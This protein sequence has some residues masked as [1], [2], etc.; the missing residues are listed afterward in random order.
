MNTV[1]RQLVP[2]AIRRR[3]SVHL[4]ALR[5]AALRRRL[6]AMAVG[7]RP[8]LA[9]PWLGEV[10]FEVLYWMPFLRWF[11][12]EYNIPPSR[13]AVISR[14]GT[15]S[16]YQPF[17]GSYHDVFDH[18]S[19][20]EFRQEHDQRI[21][22]GGQQKQTCASAFEHR[23]LD[24]VTATI[25][26]RDAAVLHPSTMY[27]IL[28]P[29][30]WKHLDER[31]VHQHTRYERLHAPAA[32]GIDSLPDSYV[33]V[34]FYFNDCFPETPRNVAFVRQVVGEIA[35]RSPVVSLSTGLGLD[36]HDAVALDGRAIVSLPMELDARTNLQV[37]SA[38]LAGA[39]AFV[40]TYGG[41][42]Y[43]A[44]FYGVPTVAYY[45][46][47]AGFSRRHLT[48]ARS[49]LASVGAAHLFDVRA[50]KDAPMTPS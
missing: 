2:R 5:S 7:T 14:G 48:M 46:D 6:A 30:W 34:K 12:T 3:A 1:L 27:E 42:S 23:L 25:G 37:Q 43:L 10:G 16:W 4:A 29:F 32:E 15:H 28:N 9:G 44:P 49:A 13:L 35:Q 11:A 47:A 50:V 41:F 45:G 22:D 38:V 19:R 17:A 20:E 24:A 8:I 18:V 36:D 26:A 33:A 31:W 40:G 39:S 21:R